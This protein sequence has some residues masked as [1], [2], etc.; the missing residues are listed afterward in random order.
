MTRFINPETLSKAI[1]RAEEEIALFPEAEFPEE[2]AEAR[3]LVAA[4]KWWQSMQWR[5]IETAPKDG[6]WVLLWIEDSAS[7]GFWNGR[8]WDDGDFY[9]DL[10]SPSYWMPLHAA[11]K[12]TP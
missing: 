3:A 8:T 6:T 12:D 4:G 7:L 9:D 5:P 11:P 1:K 2:H 10:G